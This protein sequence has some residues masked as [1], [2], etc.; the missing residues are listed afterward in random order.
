MILRGILAFLRL[1]LLP[2]LNR[3]ERRNLLDLRTSYTIWKMCGN[4]VNLFGMAKLVACDQFEPFVD[5]QHAKKRMGKEIRS[6]ISGFCFVEKHESLIANR[7]QIAQLNI[8]F[9]EPSLVNR[10]RRA[11]TKNAVFGDEKRK[12]KALQEGYR[13]RIMADDASRGSDDARFDLAEV[14]GDFCGGPGAV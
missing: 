3:F 10:E 1:V 8:F 9:A 13:T 5:A 6:E 12:V 2:L 7:T 14:C 4:F 11:E